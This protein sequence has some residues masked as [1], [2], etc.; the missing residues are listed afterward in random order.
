MEIFPLSTASDL[1]SEIAITIAYNVA[2]VIGV[3]ALGVSI[4]VVTRWFNSGT[5]MISSDKGFYNGKTGKWER[6]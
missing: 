1:V 5:K 2:I 3:L 6:W 4:F